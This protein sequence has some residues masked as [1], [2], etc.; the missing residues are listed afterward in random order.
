MNVNGEKEKEAGAVA[1]SPT[2]DKAAKEQLKP[3]D[4]IGEMIERLK[5]QLARALPKHV[6]AERLAR[7]ALTAVR[8]NPKLAQADA[9]SLMG[10]IMTAAQLGLEPNTPLGQCYIIPYNNKVK[11][12]D[13]KE[14]WM[15]QASFQMGYKGIIDLAHRSGQYR[16]ITAHAVDEADKFSYEYGLNPSLIHVPAVKPSGKVLYYYAV[17]QLTNGGYDFRVWSRDQVQAH[18]EKYSKTWDAEKKRFFYGSAWAEAFDSMGCK[19]VLIDL[20]RYAPKSVEIA[21]AASSDGR[22]MTVNPEDP[23]LN[24]D[25]IDAEF[26]LTGEAAE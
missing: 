4:S 6:T 14:K 12:A 9:M 22:T 5:P 8:N 16:Q 18:A 17:Y 25:A 2:G 23:D 3:R 10:S 1:A 13:G 24:V 19:T 20:L 7:V 11:G 26:E 15:M 21:L